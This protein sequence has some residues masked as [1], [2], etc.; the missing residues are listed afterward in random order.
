MPAAK[1]RFQIAL[2][3]GVAIDKALQIVLGADIDGGRQ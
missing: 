2:F 1:P 3:Q